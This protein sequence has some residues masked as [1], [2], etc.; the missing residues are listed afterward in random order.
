M[1]QLFMYH[2]HDRSIDPSIAASTRT[3]RRL[4]MVAL[5][6]GFALAPTATRSALA[7]RG[8][9]TLDAMTMAFV[10]SELIDDAVD[11]V[12]DDDDEDERSATEAGRGSDTRRRYAIGAHGG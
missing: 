5:T 8:A 4:T 3:T 11:G 1:Y 10:R 2:T 9:W 6:Q 7:P 12:G